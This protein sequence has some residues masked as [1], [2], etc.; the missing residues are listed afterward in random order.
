MVLLIYTSHK[1][2]IIPSVLQLMENLYILDGFYKSSI[3][4]Q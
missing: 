2:G 3:K 4:I 1:A